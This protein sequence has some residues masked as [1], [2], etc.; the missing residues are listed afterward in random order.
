MNATYK[1]ICETYYKR[2]NYTV[3][4]LRKFVING[5]LT[6]EEFEQITGEQY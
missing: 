1:K 2:G 6:E 4:D 5:K 3:E